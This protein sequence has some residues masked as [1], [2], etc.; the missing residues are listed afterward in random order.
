[1]EVNIKML[2]V[3]NISEVFMEAAGSLRTLEIVH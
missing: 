1:M 3:T 2:L